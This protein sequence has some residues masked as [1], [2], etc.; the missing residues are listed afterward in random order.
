MGMSHGYGPSKDR[1]E[2]SALIREEGGDE[3]GQVGF[4]LIFSLTTDRYVLT[5][6]SRR[7][8]SNKSLQTFSE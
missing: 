2:M 8:Y 1:K 5:G 7:I 6:A 4:Q 3:C